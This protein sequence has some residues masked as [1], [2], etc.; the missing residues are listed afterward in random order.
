MTRPFA[1]NL[2]LAVAWAALIGGFG[3][4]DLFVGFV[5]GYLVLWIL[6]P[7]LGS[8]RYCRQVIQILRLVGHFL[9]ELVTSS[10]DVARDVLSPGQSNQPA[11]VDIELDAETDLEIVALANLVSL[12]PGS[13]TIDVSDDRR[14]LYVHAMFAHDADELRRSVKGGLERRVLEAFR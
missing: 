14:T 7:L 11:I 13:L 1:I 6:C 4:A 12:T 2:L 3:I 5:I 8:E 10:V 9:G